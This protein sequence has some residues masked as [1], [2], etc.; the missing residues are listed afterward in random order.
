MK[1]PY[2]SEETFTAYATIGAGF[3]MLGE[4]QK[5][6]NKPRAPIVQ[7]IDAATGY[8]KHI[9]E[10]RL[11]NM[12]IILKDII[13]AKKVLEDDYLA[14]EQALNEC[15]AQLKSIK[16][17]TTAKKVNQLNSGK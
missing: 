8:D 14:S 17:K 10:L 16:S 2:E 4:I 13:A 9:T 3:Y 12:I 1:N 6:I 15:K 7:A 5:A 11:K